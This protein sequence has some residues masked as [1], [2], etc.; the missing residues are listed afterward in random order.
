M[1]F[2]LFFHLAPV[3][4][5]S[6]SKV[7]LNFPRANIHFMVRNET[8]EFR[9]DVDENGAKIEGYVST[10][11][12]VSATEAPTGPPGTSTGSDSA[13]VS[14]TA[15]PGGPTDTPNA[16]RLVSPQLLGLLWPWGCCFSLR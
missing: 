6:T 8:G 2:P 12:A 10:S 14:T 7:G 3:W 13:P 15:G 9:G 5:N 11:T 4:S 16:A 1:T